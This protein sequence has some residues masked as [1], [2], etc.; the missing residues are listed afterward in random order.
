MILT[1]II[2][3]IIYLALIWRFAYGFD[4]V[5]TFKLTDL[6]SK[7]QFSILIPFRNEAKNL[8]SLL[9]SLE[10]LNYP[11]HLFEI[12]FIDD[13]STDGS[14][15]IITQ[16]FNKKQQKFKII[17]NDRQT[18]SPKKDAITTA[19]KQAKH[20]W[21]ITTDADCSL[22]K[23]WL[24][25]FDEFIQ[26]TKAKCIAAPV[27]YNKQKGFLN[28][29]QTLDLLSLQGATIGGFGIKKPFLCNGANFGYT[30]TLFKT[31]N[32]FEGNTNI[33]SG[34]DIFLLEKAV[35]KH[36]K[37]THYLKCKHA[38]VKT[39]AQPSWS[40]LIEQRLRWA[41]KASAYNNF[42]GKLT[43]LIVLLIN[44]IIISIILLSFFGYFPLKTLFYILLIKF[45]IDFYLIHKTASFF[46]QK[47]VL[48]SFIP[49]FCIYPFFSVY[50]AFLSIFKT[51]KW[52]GREFKK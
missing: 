46:N 35:K 17:G 36:P 19:I 24:D 50:I 5:L 20:E 8:S 12:V 22:P 31:V 21:I 15:E 25:S 28:R 10:N 23:Y 41:S 27:A 29:F 47:W 33:A 44:T 6:A 18:N 52:K 14:A 43:G 39:N 11:K 48:K 2:I 1:S 9:L 13:D 7:T 38:I 42:F 37:N 51:Y 4:K 49:T 40:S 26:K 32:G 16:Y 45:S 34:D 30:K 3:S